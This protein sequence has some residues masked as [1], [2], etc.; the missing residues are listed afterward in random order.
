[1]ERWF[2]NRQK[3]RDCE[4]LGA[5]VGRPA[6]SWATEIARRC[7]RPPGSLYPT[8]VRLESQRRVVSWWAPG[9]WPRRRLYSL[10]PGPDSTSP[11]PGPAIDPE[12]E[13]RLAAEPVPFGRCRAAHDHDDFCHEAP[14]EDEDDEP[15]PCDT[16]A[17]IGQIWVTGSTA[18]DCHCDGGYV[19]TIPEPGSTKDG[20]E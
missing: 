17:G 18:V 1:M 6:G 15:I 19:R 12:A 10:A 20:T 9:P 13:A 5:L 2:T 7:G 11:E 16:C 4:V 8:L 14:L 3:R